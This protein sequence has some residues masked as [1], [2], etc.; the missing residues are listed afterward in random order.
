MSNDQAVDPEF[1]Q[2]PDSPELLKDLETPSESRL[3]DIPADLWPIV[4]R[5]RVAINMEQEAREAM[6]RYLLMLNED[7]PPRVGDMIVPWTLLREEDRPRIP[8]I[9]IIDGKDCLVLLPGSGPYPY[10]LYGLGDFIVVE[11]SAL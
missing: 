2:C 1:D 8:I 4:K 10:A 3:V 9:D 7:H 5:H 11:R 6:R